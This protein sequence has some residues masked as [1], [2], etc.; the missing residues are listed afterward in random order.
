MKR[1]QKAPLAISD[2]ANSLLPVRDSILIASSLQMKREKLKFGRI[3]NQM[4]RI[5]T[6]FGHISESRACK[7]SFY[8]K[9]IHT[10]NS[11]FKTVP[12]QYQKHN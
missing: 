10:K 1:S 5:R 9:L 11:T 2:L 8:I 6:S 12:F 3:Y 7:S 4:M